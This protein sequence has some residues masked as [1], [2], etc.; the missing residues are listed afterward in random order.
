MNY[1]SMNRIIRPALRIM[2]TGTFPVNTL[3][4]MQLVKRRLEDTI[5]N[6]QCQL[7]TMTLAET[8][9]K[10]IAKKISPDN[11][12]KLSD[13]FL[14]QV[15]FRNLDDTIDVTK[16]MDNHD[17]KGFELFYFMNFS[18]IPTSFGWL[19]YKTD[20]ETLTLEQAEALC[21]EHGYYFDWFNGKA[22]KTRFRR[23]TGETQEL[24]RRRIDARNF[25]G[26]TYKSVLMALQH[27]LK[28]KS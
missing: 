7:H 13:T 17:I 5:Y 6:T 23:Q 28:N 19:E 18:N 4:T 16:L 25:D 24:Q 22:F 26:C 21:K 14:N 2:S 15:E 8:Q 12:T 1:K 11:S 20:N 27:K 3:G 10:D 9:I